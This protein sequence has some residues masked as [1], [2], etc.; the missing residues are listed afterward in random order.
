MNRRLYVNA[1][2][3]QL[4]QGLLT[5]FLRERL[6]PEIG[7][8]NASAADFPEAR[9]RRL[10]RYLRKN[11]LGCTLHAPFFGLDAAAD[12]MT[13]R[14]KTATAL[15]WAFSLLPIFRP[16]A[17]VCHPHL[18]DTGD[19]GAFAERLSLSRR[20]WRPL[21]ARAAA[22]EV[23]VMF[24]NTYETN[25]AGHRGF[26]AGLDSRFARFCL[27]SGHV[28]A[29][30]RN[31]W[32]DWLPTLEPW[33]G[34]LHLHDNDGS[35]DAHLGLGLGGFGFDELFSYLNERNL[36]PTVTLEPHSE[37][38]LRQSLR[39]L[40]DNHAFQRLLAAPTM[41]SAQ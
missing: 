8:N 12:D 28:L 3:W 4:E 18:V 17:I 23:P 16:A 10:A 25:A 9:L 30:A 32:R 35:A 21:V 29:F 37:F 40:A 27:D 13:V 20:F 22:N 14:Q 38:D 5:T 6:Q 15:A 11:D 26:L 19:A 34:H 1:P 31:H 24:E 7:L 36:R 39:Y 2:L 41:E 33:L